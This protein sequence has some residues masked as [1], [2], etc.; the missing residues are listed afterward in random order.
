MVERDPETATT[1]G[2]KILSIT[3]MES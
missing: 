2:V 3:I 1:P